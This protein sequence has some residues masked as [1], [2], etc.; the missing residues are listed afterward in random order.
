VRSFAVAA[1][2]LGALAAQGNGM[3]ESSIQLWHWVRQDRSISVCRID[4]LDVEPGGDDE[5]VRVRLATV[6]TLWGP[7]AASGRRASFE[8]PVSPLVR[9]KT[10][11]PVWGHVELQPGA[12]LLY[13]SDGP[14]SDAKPIFAGNTSA[15][16]PALAAVRQVTAFEGEHGDEPEVRKSRYLEWLAKG[17]LVQRLFAGEA[18]TRD[19]LP[20]KDRDGQIAGA[21]AKVVGEDSAQPFLRISALEWLS[22][23]WAVTSAAG[24]SAAIRGEAMALSA[25][26]ANVRQFAYDALVDLDPPKLRKEKI[27]DPETAALLRKQAAGFDEP[28][29]ARLKAL[30]NALMARP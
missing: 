15:E 27:A 25:K 19:D 7:K 18:L 21:V 17:S 24:K 16:D 26:D 11:I 23:L 1:L 8:R 14:A 2:A 13:V 4:G 12:L 20:R 10:Q 29:R 9:L 3:N 5:T 6:D 28:G 22:R 30:A